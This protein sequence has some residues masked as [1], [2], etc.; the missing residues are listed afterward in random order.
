MRAPN[1]RLLEFLRRPEAVEAL[2]RYSVH[3]PPPA[4]PDAAAAALRR[5]KYP[6]AACEVP[7]MHLR[8]W[9]LGKSWL[10]CV[11]E[12]VATAAAALRRAKF[13]Q[14]AC[15]VAYPVWGA[16]VFNYGLL[17]EHT[18]QTV[19]QLDTGLRAPSVS[20]ALYLSYY[21]RCHTAVQLK[22]FASQA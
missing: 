9:G 16:E 21:L 11:L 18:R 8:A 12:Q 2:L 6:Q 17:H 15:G 20:Q 22:R 10:S 3:P 1:A 14:A 13:P 5:A 19:M 7:H 4:M